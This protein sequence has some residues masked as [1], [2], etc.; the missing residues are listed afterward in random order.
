LLSIP[1]FSVL[2]ARAFN[3][4]KSLVKILAHKAVLKTTASKQT[5]SI[6]VASIYLTTTNSFFDIATPISPT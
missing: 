6:I 2:P 1:I 5:T 4:A 3:G